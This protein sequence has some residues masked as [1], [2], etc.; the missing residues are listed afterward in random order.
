VLF[1][2]RD[3]LSELVGVGLGD[4][5]WAVTELHL[6]EVDDAVASIEE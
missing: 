5:V 3:L 1:E 6:A 2:E 4:H